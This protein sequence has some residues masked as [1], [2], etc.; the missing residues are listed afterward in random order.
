VH[1]RTFGQF[2]DF[3]FAGLRRDDVDPVAGVI[4]IRG[5]EVRPLPAGAAGTDGHRGAGPLSGRA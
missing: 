5:G 3:R 4:A 2:A 1:S